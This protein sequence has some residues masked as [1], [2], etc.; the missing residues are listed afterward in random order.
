MKHLLYEQEQGLAEARAEGMVGLKVASEEHKKAED[1]HLA[2]KRRLQVSGK[3]RS[4][5]LD[6]R[7]SRLFNLFSLGPTAGQGP[8]IHG[9]PS[10]C[11]IETCRA[12]RAAEAV[13][14]GE[15]ATGDDIATHITTA[16]RYIHWAV[17]KMGKPLN[18]IYVRSNICHA[19]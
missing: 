18:L 17:S 9:S 10:R 2:D 5:H 13:V 11:L 14:R 6:T 16:Y 3:L 8:P 19:F 12:A 7:H 1:L 15:S 4:A